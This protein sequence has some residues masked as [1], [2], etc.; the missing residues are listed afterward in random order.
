MAKEAQDWICT[1]KWVQGTPSYGGWIWTVYLVHDNGPDELE[2]G[3][4]LN[5]LSVYWKVWR[6]CRKHG[7]KFRPWS[8]TWR[9]GTLPDGT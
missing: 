1:V 3:A 5:K 9:S 8:K 2:S 6:V 4:A 7:L